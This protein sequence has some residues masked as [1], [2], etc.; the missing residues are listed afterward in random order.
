ML[1]HKGPK[2]SLDESQMA[3]TLFEDDSEESNHFLS[4]E[5]R[6]DSL[7]KLSA[8][9]SF[10]PTF[11]A[12]LSLMGFYCFSE[13]FKMLKC[14][15]CKFLSPE[16]SLRKLIR[17]HSVF[18]P[19]CCYA[20][21]VEISTEILNRP[22]DNAAHLIAFN[23]FN[24]LYTFTDR[25]VRLSEALCVEAAACGLRFLPF[26]RSVK[27]TSCEFEAELEDSGNFLALKLSEMHMK[28]NP[29][30]HN[31]GDSPHLAKGGKQKGIFFI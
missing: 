19:R 21:F 8:W 13:T 24:N 6:E 7:V 14:Y 18:S 9:S 20:K 25:Y 22:E 28:H 1:V 12:I 29:K 15:F 26:K 3:M 17:A 23:I 16:T 10:T 31:L 30:C 2:E 5:N 27:C 11:A 4:R